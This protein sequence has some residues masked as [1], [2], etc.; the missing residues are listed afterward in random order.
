MLQRATTVFSRFV[1]PAALTAAG[2]IGAGA[3]GMGEFKAS[4]GRNTVLAATLLFALGLG[5]TGVARFFR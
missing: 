3:V 4:F 5:V 1:G 2:R